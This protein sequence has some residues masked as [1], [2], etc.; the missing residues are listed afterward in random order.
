[1]KVYII[2][3]LRNPQVPKLVHVLRENWPEHEFF[4]DWYAAGPEADDRWRDYELARGRTPATALKGHAA[5]HVYNYDR[6][7]LQKS[8]VVILVAPAGKSGHLELGVA[9]GWGK[10]SIYYMADA[11]DRWDVML[12]FCDKVVDSQDKLLSAL[13][14]VLH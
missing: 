8:D 11:P 13:A 12:Q 3:S 7:H 4:D 10:H 6:E 14:A 9:I 1:V 5:R 2:G